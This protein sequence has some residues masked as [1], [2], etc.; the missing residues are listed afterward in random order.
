MKRYAICFV[1]PALTLLIFGCGVQRQSHEGVYL[2]DDLVKMKEFVGYP[3]IPGYA[4]CLDLRPNKN[5]ATV[6]FLESPDVYELRVEKSDNG[7]YL[8]KGPNGI[9]KAKVV[10][11]FKPRELLDCPYPF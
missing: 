3:G 9:R 4:Y 10:A 5:L 6:K 11:E 2:M 8:L 1:T 7:D